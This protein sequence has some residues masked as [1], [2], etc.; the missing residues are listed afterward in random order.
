MALSTRLF[1]RLTAAEPA[2]A[3]APV[4]PVPRAAD[5]A[6]PTPSVEMLDCSSACSVMSPTASTVESSMVAVIVPSTSL[7][8]MPTPMASAPVLLLCLVEAA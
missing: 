1:T 2:P 7:I 3:I 8:A 6:T 4:A 5:A